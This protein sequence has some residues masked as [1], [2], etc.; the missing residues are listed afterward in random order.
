M[1]N[2][3]LTFKGDILPN[4]DPAHVR[5]GLAELFQVRDPLVMDELFSGDTFVLR[6]NLGRKSAADYF[7]KITDIG[8]VAE[9]VPTESS[10]IPT[11]APKQQVM[12]RVQKENTGV[13]FASSPHRARRGEI[14]RD[15]AV[16][17]LFNP[18]ETSAT[19][20]EPAVPPANEILAK[21]QDLKLDAKTSHKSK[22][23]QLNQMQKEVK[24]ENASA[25]KNVAV[26]REAALLAAKEKFARLQQLEAESK[27]QLDKNL[28]ILSAEEAEKKHKL[29]RQIKQVNEQTATAL[30]KDE[31]TATQLEIDRST[32]QKLAEETIE[33]LKA[34][35]AASEEQ[36][37]RD[38][39]AIDRLQQEA[40]AVLQQEQARLAMKAESLQEAY[41]QA[42]NS[43]RI[44][45]QEHEQQ[46]MTEVSEIR[47]LRQL[48]DRAREDR[49]AELWKQEQQLNNKVQ[50]RL[51]ELE[52]IR[53]RHEQSLDARLR[54]FKEEE[55]KIKRG[56]V[57]LT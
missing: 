16:D 52:K 2:F 47:H 10:A 12:T 43:L 50:E 19:I 53:A 4:Y 1:K 36:V 7:R 9:L 56:E 28:S 30:K 40:G 39:L 29:Q 14:I 24:D 42:I 20:L 11:D 13:F 26:E 25:L 32:C 35:I 57:A 44:Q 38:L 27:E 34:K 45:R 49:L 51:N 48:A 18:E 33:S 21:L 46:Q 3:D 17:T 31:G 54:R 22:L 15:P 55:E 41:Q 23:K 37:K 5:E 6:S 8:G